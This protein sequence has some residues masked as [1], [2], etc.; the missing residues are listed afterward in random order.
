MVGAGLSRSIG[1]QELRSHLTTYYTQIRQFDVTALGVTAYRE[2]LRQAMPYSLQSAIREECGDR[3]VTLPT[4][5]QTA[6]LP[7][8]CAPGLDQAAVAKASAKL[9]AADLDEDL[10]RHIADLDQKIAGFERFGRLARGLRLDL[11]TVDRR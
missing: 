5:A 4:G 3:V 6:T 2:R 9:A 1:D 11:E 7:D 8:Q 10:T